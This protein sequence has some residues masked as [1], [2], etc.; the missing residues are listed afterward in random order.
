M[1]I[2]EMEG[3]M[4]TYPAIKHRKIS[5][6]KALVSSLF[7]L[8]AIAFMIF[9]VYIPFAWNGVLSFQ[10]WNGFSAPKWI[11]F[12]NY[13]NLL[14]D[15]VAQRGLWNSIFLAVFSTL[16]AVILGLLLAAF[17]YKVTEREGAFYRLIIFLPVM[18]PTAVVGLLFA[19]V[20]NPEM[21]LL[22][23]FLRV[24]GLDSFTHVWLEEKATVM[25]C[26]V[27]VNIWKMSGL[28]M[29]LSF[30]SMKML[31]E[32]IFESS[33]LEGATYREQFLKLILPLIKPTVLLSAVY[34]LVVNFKSYDIVFVLTGGGPG[35]TSQTVPIN[36]VKTAFNFSEFG[37]AAAMGM[38]FALVVMLVVAIVNRVLKGETYE[39]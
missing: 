17:V 2:R 35:T 18:L 30:A 9:S 38:I 37:Y 31:P 26:I 27:A 34:T 21:G 39:Y 15:A 13:K 16:G 20:F 24:I 4:K 36:M 3:Y 32:S 25:W 7:L 11:G 33:K 28:T 12:D 23:N 19:F 6:R 22:N 8:P 5:W 10:K 14:T 29:M 1:E